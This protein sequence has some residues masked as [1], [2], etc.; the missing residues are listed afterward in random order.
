M[1]TKSAHE[2]RRSPNASPRH[3]RPGS[4]HRLRSGDLAELVPLPQCQLESL[5]CG[6][7]C[8][9]GH[10]AQA[11]Y[12]SGRCSGGVALV[13]RCPR[14]YAAGV[15]QGKPGSGRSR[16]L[17]ERANVLASHPSTSSLTDDLLVISPSP[18]AL[19]AIAP[20]PGPSE[21]LFAHGI[22]RF[23]ALCR[24]AAGRAEAYERAL[25]V[26][27]PFLPALAVSPHS[28]SLHL[29]RFQCFQPARSCRQA[30]AKPWRWLPVHGVGA[31]QQRSSPQPFS[32][33]P[34]S[35]TRLR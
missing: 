3:P 33:L 8:G 26:S 35:G 9:V 19:C 4:G 25:A 21:Q 32:V 27:P 5:Q 12:Q 14:R 1:R 29:Q 2:S 22:S 13:S 7:P 6:H 30:L 20:I 31:N 18:L 17:R 11:I 24:S 34:C 16:R 23:P 10:E 15:E 28:F